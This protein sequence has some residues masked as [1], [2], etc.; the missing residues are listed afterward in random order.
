[1][2]VQ[3][4]PQF[5]A[6]LVDA[7]GTLIYPSEPAAEVLARVQRHHCMG[8]AD[9][10]ACSCAVFTLPNGLWEATKD[11]REYLLSSSCE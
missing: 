10:P 4:Q 1:M 5:K 6:L 2:A 11:L 8:H 9:T 3:L 7:A